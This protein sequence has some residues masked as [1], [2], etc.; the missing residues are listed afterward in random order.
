ML[1][2][3]N[4]SRVL[5]FFFF[6]LLFSQ[7]NIPHLFDYYVFENE[8]HREILPEAE[9]QILFENAIHSIILINAEDIKNTYLARAYFYRGLNFAL[10]YMETVDNEIWVTKDFKVLYTVV[11]GVKE[12]MHSYA[13]T[14]QDFAQKSVDA[15][16]TADGLVTLA[17][18]RFMTTMNKNPFSMLF[19]WISFTSMV[20]KA[21][22]LE[23]SNVNAQML[24][25]AIDV[26]PPPRF[27]NIKKG[28]RDL[29]IL[30]R[31]DKPLSPKS[32]N[33]LICLL[34]VQAFLQIDDPIQTKKWLDEA[35]KIYNG[36][37]VKIYQIRLAELENKK[38]EI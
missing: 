2:K 22:K 38:N 13:I 35:Q 14:A 5:I 12:I 17:L 36:T 8:V 28:I 9:M 32:D 37:I 20:K 10:K 25:S 31:Q 3:K 23:P 1:S 19:S 15:N 16:P 18:L 27:G 29:E 7:T 4:T 33:Y 6:S 30:I 24:L 34:F 21:A 11:I 26:M